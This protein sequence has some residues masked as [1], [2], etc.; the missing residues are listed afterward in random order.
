MSIC[1][2][3]GMEFDAVM[4]V[5]VN[6]EHF[7]NDDLHARLL[8]VL[9][10]RAQHELKIFRYWKGSFSQQ[11]NPLPSLMTSYEKAVHAHP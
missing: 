9:V 8:Y 3:K 7:P 2:S 4:L 6:G 5:N 11:P 10:T 1:H